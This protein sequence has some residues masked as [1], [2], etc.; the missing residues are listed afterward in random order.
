[1]T[2]LSNI[3]KLGQFVPVEKIYEIKYKPLVKSRSISVENGES[4]IIDNPDQEDE[5]IERIQERVKNMEEQ[6]A[7][8]KQDMM[9]ETTVK[10]AKEMDIARKQANDEK[11]KILAQARF[12]ANQLIEQAKKEGYNQGMIQSE[13]RISALIQE[14]NKLFRETQEHQK[15]EILNIIEQIN[16]IAID[17]AETIL[18]KKIQQDEMELVHLVADAI[19]ENR[20]NDWTSVELPSHMRKLIQYIDENFAQKI[21]QFKIIHKKTH[22]KNIECIIDTPHGIVDFSIKTQLDNLRQ[23]LKDY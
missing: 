8:K 20:F 16:P 14:V 4:V 17:V 12:E 21:D 19:E 13:Q 1:M 11:E 5:H 18:H 9:I 15:K 7:Q 2:E 6:M 3:Y 23:M 22:D 10:I